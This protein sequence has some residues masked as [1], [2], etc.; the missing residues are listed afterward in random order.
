MTKLEELKAFA[1]TLDATADAAFGYAANAAAN[2]AHRLAR[3]AQDAYEAELKAAD[4]SAALAYA[5]A[6]PAELKKTEE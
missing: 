1:E 2:A 4:A 3:D 6:N 5:R